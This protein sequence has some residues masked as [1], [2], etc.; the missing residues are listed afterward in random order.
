MP[1][2]FSLKNP[3]SIIIPVFNEARNIHEL[4][5]ELKLYNN[6][7]HE[8]IIVDDGS[9]DGSYE[10]LQEQE[11]IMLYRF[12]RN[13]GKGEAIKK[14]IIESNNEK[15]ILFDAD[16]ELHPK[17]ISKLMILDYQK[18]I[19]CVFGNR[20]NISEPKSYWDIGNIIFTKLFNWVNQSNLDD[21]LCCA[22]SFFKLVI[23]LEKLKSKKFDIDVEILSQLISNN[24]KITTV[25]IDYRRRG[26]IEGKK[27]KTID[28][29]RIFLKILTQ[30][31]TK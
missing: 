7:G 29:F 4:I 25:D 2:F 8:I 28:G 24:S 19:N 13:K 26:K 21:V 15:L 18:G 14:G 17:D 30:W 11:F 1:L 3:Y 16:F 5:N 22:K 23:V 10:A 20:Y 6:E 27:L 9:N 31:K 12:E